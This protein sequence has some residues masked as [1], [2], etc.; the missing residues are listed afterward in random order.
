LLFKCILKNIKDLKLF[1]STLVMAE[2]YILLLD[3][4]GGRITADVVKSRLVRICGGCTIGNERPG[5]IR[6]AYSLQ[7]QN[8]IPS[9]EMDDLE[10]LGATISRAR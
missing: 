10:R 1:L 6:T 2:E 5:G 7:T 9:E 3:N 8:P 4:M